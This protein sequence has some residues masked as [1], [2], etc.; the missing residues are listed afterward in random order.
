MLRAQRPRADKSAAL[1][2]D[3]AEQH[4]RDYL[5]GHPEVLK[6]AQVLRI[7]GTLG[8]VIRDRVVR[9]AADPPTLNGLIERARSGKAGGD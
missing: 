5:V 4:A 3:Q 6:L 1:S 2:R 7:S 8:F 9:G